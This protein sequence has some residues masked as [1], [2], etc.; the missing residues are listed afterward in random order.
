MHD[1]QKDQ[2]L[3]MMLNPQSGGIILADYNAPK[4]ALYTSDW[5]KKIDNEKKSWYQPMSTKDGYVYRLTIS[6]HGELMA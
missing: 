2:A 4:V 6:G 5:P 3:I 1:D